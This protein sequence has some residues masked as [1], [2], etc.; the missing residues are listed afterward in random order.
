ME[1]R[2]YWKL[3]IRR[4]PLVVL[5]AA[6]VLAIGL[7]TY[8]APPP[9][10]N[11]GVGF[12]VAQRP[13]LEAL[14]SDQERYHNWLASEYIVNALVD[15]VEGGAFA[16]AVSQQLAAEEK[17]EVPAAAIHGGLVVENERSKLVLSFSHGD[18]STLAAIVE[19]ATTVLVEQSNNAIPQLEEDPAVFVELGAPVIS[20][21]P[22]GIRS[23]LD[24]PL[25]VVLALV[26]GGGLA[27]LVEYF[28]PTVRE[29]DE[30]EALG[31]SVLAEIPKK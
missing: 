14:T 13:S 20:Q 27:L 15:W 25:R 5:P 4:W 21:V 29:R 3:F 24:L 6:V 8:Q 19:A 18:A 31:L 12:I 9:L 2:R 26:T 22:P 10:Y 7:A 1:L 11:A 23:Q 28:D 16:E 17:G 30:V